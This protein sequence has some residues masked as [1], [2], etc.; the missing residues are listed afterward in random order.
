MRGRVWFPTAGLLV[1][2]CCLNAGSV[3]AG[4]VVALPVDGSHWLSMKILVKELTRRGHEVTVLV[5]ESSLL[6]KGS[7]S[8]KTEI[9]PVPYTQAELDSILNSFRE[10]VFEKHPGIMDL[11]ANVDR[12]VNFTS[13]QVTACESLLDNEPLM[14]QLKNEGFDILLTDPFLPCGSV[15]AKIL[16][17]PA[18]Y[19]LRGL[20]CE[21]DVKANQCPS[22]PSY[23]PKFFSGNT[24]RMDFPQR[25]NNMLM[26]SLESYLCTVLYKPFDGLTGRLFDMTYK[27]LISEGAIWLLRHDFTFEWPKPLMPNMILIGGINCAKKAP[28]PADLK[29]FVEGSGDDG[30]IVFT[31]GSYVASMPE[32]KA[33]MFL[34]A[35]RQI[36]Q[37]VVW[38]YTGVLPKDIPK[39]VRI[40][41]WLPQNDL[42]AHPN[43]KVFMT[44]GGTHGIYEGI[45]NAVPM[46]MFPLFGDQR[47]NVH[48]MVARGVAEEMSIFEV[49]TEKLV[50]ALSRMIQDK[51]YKER[52]VEL[53]QIHLDRPVEPLDLA[54]FWTEFVIRH[55]GAPHLR[56]AAHDLNWV[57]YHSLDVV[58]FLLTVLVVTLWVMLKSCQFCTRKFCGKKTTKKKSE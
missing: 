24:D 54:V 55:K 31:L 20:P 30:F 22:P 35:F 38:R 33:K 57:Q 1:W 56:V 9:Y 46:L 34:D 21:L 25:V 44:H 52:V 3:Q 27:E 39:N 19:F 50:A 42:L 45:C 12:L 4:K 17:I 32:E 10:G 40:L 29:E 6:I 41:K 23:V 37:R 26:F 5:P 43:A 36:P 2:L 18:V 49:T 58:G 28:L 48:R 13:I 7:D 15:L 14:R 47:D 51:S 8:Y 16:S 11:F 53:S